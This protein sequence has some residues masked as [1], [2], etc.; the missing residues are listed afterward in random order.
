MEEVISV[1][2]IY[3][4]R[5]I[6][7]AVEIRKADLTD[8]AGEE[9]DSLELHFNDPKGLWSQWKP[10][11]NH[12]IQVIESGFDSG[13]MYT[14]EIGQQR[15]LIVLKTL[16]IKQEAKTE[17][18]KTWENTHILGVSQELAIKHGLTLEHY[19][20]DDYLY[21]RLDQVERSDFD[22]LAWRCLLEGYALKLSNGKLIIYD[23]GFM[24]APAPVKT[25][26]PDYVDG[27]YIFRNK[28]N[29]VYGSCLISSPN[30]EIQFETKAEAYGPTLK[31]NNFTLNNID[32]AK[33]FSK[34]LLRSK[35]KFEQ[36]F[37]CSVQ[38]DPGIAAGSTIALKNFGLAD[39][40]YLAYQVIQKFVSRKSIL[41]LRKLVN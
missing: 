31:F 18:T 33:R 39:G 14:D 37:S 28:S 25:L 16:P 40:K 3:E 34:G 20:V 9:L 1:R 41:K 7:E 23:E 15:G 13:V 27:D 10:E 8:N 22:F 38:L 21:T 19:G 32:E 6:N 29:Q 4:G 35:N 11:K 2:L 30:K 26:T 24:E 17:N 5:D 36:T 12:T